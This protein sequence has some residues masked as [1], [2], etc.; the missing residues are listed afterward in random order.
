MRRKED[1][2]GLA[3]TWKQ[4]RVTGYTPPSIKHEATCSPVDS[5]QR[6]LNCE[7]QPENMEVT[8]VFR[9]C[10]CEVS[11]RFGAQF[12]VECVCATTAK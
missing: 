7:H 2:R 6:A 9:K 10:S 5:E 3:V 8:S 1:W 11:I 12:I 4:P